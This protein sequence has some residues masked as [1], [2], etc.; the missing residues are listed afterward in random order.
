MVPIESPYMRLLLVNNTDLYHVSHH[1]Q[2]IKLSLSTGM[3]LFCYVVRAEAPNCGMRNL[4]SD[5][6][7]TP[8]CGVQHISIY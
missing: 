2:V 7:V 6:N 5:K 8:L 3:P 4:T 1:F